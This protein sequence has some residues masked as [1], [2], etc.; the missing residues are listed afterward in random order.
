MT[1]VSKLARAQYNKKYEARDKILFGIQAEVRGKYLKVFTERTAP[2][3][4]PISAGHACC[5]GTAKEW[6]REIIRDYQAKHPGIEF[7]EINRA[8]INIATLLKEI[9]AWLTI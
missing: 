3:L 1:D 4:H 7:K 9:H 8:K 2:Y 5:Y 6:A